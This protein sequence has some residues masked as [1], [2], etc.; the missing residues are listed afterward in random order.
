MK[1][2]LTATS[3]LPSYGGPAFSVSRLALALADA[4]VEVGLWASDMSAAHTPLLAPHPRLRALTGP[5]AAALDG[6]GTPHIVHDNGIWLAHNHHIAV[7][8]TQQNLPRVV[9]SRGML[10]PWARSHKKLKKRLAWWLY[11]RSD[12]CHAAFHHA[13]AATEAACLRQLRLGVPVGVIPNGV[14]PAAVDRRAR[15]GSEPRT[16]LFLGRVHPV[17]GLSLLVEAWAAV[18]PPGWQLQIAGPDEASHRAALERQIS[19]AGISAAIRFLGPLDEEGKRRAFG[20]ADLFVLPSL[21]ESFGMAIGEALAHG[22]PVLTTTAAPW[23]T[24]ASRAC[25]W[26]VD[27]TVDAIA[28]GLRAATSLDE[29]VLAAMGERGRDLV[30][31]DFTW[32]SVARQFIATYEALLTH[33]NGM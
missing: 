8:A 29:T 16:A 18:R 13:T 11:Q 10:E 2:F 7:I 25:G 24:L 6:F 19:A 33:K 20:G 3:L 15:P 1:L 4:G 5:I 9:S 22:L 26:S 14:E 31:N 27:P 21:S 28:A 30:T 17:K 12:L 32:S 23:P